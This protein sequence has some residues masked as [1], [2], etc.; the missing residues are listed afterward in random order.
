MNQSG[1][2][3]HSGTK[4]RTVNHSINH[5]VPGRIA[6]VKG[7]LYADH[8]TGAEPAEAPEPYLRSDLVSAAIRRLLDQRAGVARDLVQL[9][10]QIESLILDLGSKKDDPQDVETYDG[11]LGVSREFVLDFESPVGQLQWQVLNGKFALTGDD[12][13]NVSGQRWCSGALISDDLFLTAGHAFRQEFRAWKIPQ[14]AGMTLTPNEIAPLMMVTFGYQKDGATGE[15]RPGVSYPVLGLVET[16]YFPDD[17]ASSVDYAIVRLGR[18]AKGKLPGKVF[19]ILKAAQKDLSVPNA[20]I[21]I[22]QHP[23]RK[24]KKVEAGHLLQ[25]AGGRIAYNDVGTCGGASGAPVLDEATGEIIGVHVRGGSL[26]IGGFNS[27]TAIGAIREVS[28]VMA[29][30]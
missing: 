8:D 12:Q 5:P 13:G 2:M 4:G 29:G 3:N 20:R 22:I 18:D 15:I 23:N 16:G 1:A 26:P 6:A 24:E 28:K 14:R 30:L 9:D 10:T 27:G 7:R 21:C 25:T 19:G 11:S 17:P